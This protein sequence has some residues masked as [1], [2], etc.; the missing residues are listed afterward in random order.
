MLSKFVAKILYLQFDKETRIKLDQYPYIITE[1]ST[2]LFIG[3]LNL[4]VTFLHNGPP[5]TILHVP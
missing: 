3:L 1:K 5:L 4:R 2:G